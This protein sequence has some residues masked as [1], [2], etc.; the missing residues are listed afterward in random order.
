MMLMVGG[1]ISNPE[2]ENGKSKN[3]LL[4]SVFLRGENQSFQQKVFLEQDFA[5]R[6]R[7]GLN[8]KISTI[9]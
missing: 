1:E 3:G 9:L 8:L 5:Y 7:K 4:Y 6:E 2:K